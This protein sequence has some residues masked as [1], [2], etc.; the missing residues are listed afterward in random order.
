MTQD[1]YDETDAE[2]RSLVGPLLL[3][4]AIAVLAAVAL[5]WKDETLDP[6]LAWARGLIAPAGEAARD[7]APAG[8][9]I[10]AWIA[11]CDATAKTCAL[12]QDLRDIGE[13]KLDAAWRIEA[14][15][16]DLFGVWT[17]P[18]GILVRGGMQLGFDDRKPVSVPYD[19]CAASSCEVRAKLTPAFVDTLRTARGS[20]A[21]VNLKD[22][23]AQAFPFSHEGLAK[24]LELLPVAEARPEQD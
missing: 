7:A 6:A 3:I 9:R 21:G 8:R 1:E 15:G 11:Q 5:V 12:T 18:T 13:R 10:G 24:A 19:S 17:L 4:L 20:V 22:G 2:R 14:Q 23:H 16:G